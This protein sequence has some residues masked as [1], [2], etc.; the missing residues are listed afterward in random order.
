[1]M[2]I[3]L[4]FVLRFPAAVELPSDLQKEGKNSFIIVNVQ[5]VYEPQA[6]PAVLLKHT[7]VTPSVDCIYA[8]RERELRSQ[9]VTA[10]TLKKVK[11]AATIPRR[12]IISVKKKRS[13]HHSLAVRL[14]HTDVKS[15]H[16][17]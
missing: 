15:G 1:M 12:A 6:L 8:E 7:R 3:R 2:V 17:R 14:I 16:R 4:T 11:T 10:D 5:R 13:Q 9:V